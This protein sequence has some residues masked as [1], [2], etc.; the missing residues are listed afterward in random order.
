MC[1]ELQLHLKY[2]GTSAQ[3]LEEVQRRRRV[4]WESYRL[5]RF[6][7]STLGRPFAIIDAIITVEYPE[8]C[9]VTE[10][11]TL[12]FWENVRHQLPRN[13]QLTD[14]KVFIH[15]LKLSRITSQLHYL[16]QLQRTGHSESDAQGLP[17][18]AFGAR[19]GYGKLRLLA[20]ELQEWRRDI[21]SY[22]E[23]A[24]PSQVKESF[25]LCFHKENLYLIRIAI[26]L[27]SS[28]RGRR[29]PVYLMGPCM[30]A[31]CNLIETF[32]NLRRGGLVPW[33][34]ANTYLIFMTSLII[35]FVT[36][37][38]AQSSPHQRE[39]TRR[40]P[41]LVDV[42]SWWADLVEDADEHPTQDK[43][44]HALSVAAA[45][46][47]WMASHM[48]DI[49]S[50]AQCL[51]VL[52]HELER[53]IAKAA[54]SL[55]V[56]RMQASSIALAP[57]VRL[58]ITENI[59]EEP[60]TEHF[61]ESM[62]NRFENQPADYTDPA[63]TGLGPL[64]LAPDNAMEG[65]LSNFFPTVENPGDFDVFQPTQGSWPFSHIPWFESIYPEM[66]GFDEDIS[67]NQYL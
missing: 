41:S 27:S 63:N 42:E 43:Q 10:L 52:R 24:C 64:D 66:S 49:Q 22:D 59:P 58:D 44:L 33:T 60:S 1:I 25:E 55:D 30:M 57:D 4:F 38:Q 53:E 8:C 67:F 54:S 3:E 20:A 21:P 17:K 65:I 2:D 48:P 40:D 47:D 16:H 6:S 7:S 13:D 51:E 5:D 14:G 15:L 32:D 9:P 39:L 61:M 36:F 28:S 26:D 31:A 23:P 34:R 56:A 35:V 19:E 11:R 46:L 62:P 12:G 37:S 18:S 45:I 50:Y 29:P